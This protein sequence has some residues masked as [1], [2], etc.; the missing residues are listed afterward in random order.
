MTRHEEKKEMTTMMMMTIKKFLEF[1]NANYSACNVT[2]SAV[3]RN[4]TY[5]FKAVIRQQHHSS[6]NDDY[7]CFEAYMKHERKRMNSTQK[8]ERM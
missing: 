4:S 2:R 6:D 3:K 5:D 8:R 7:Y 1:I